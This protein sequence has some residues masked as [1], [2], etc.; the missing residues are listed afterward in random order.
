MKRDMD[1][2]RE[3]LLQVEARPTAQSIDLVE[4]PGH[5]QEEISY[6]VKLLADAGYLEAHDLR[7]LGPDGFKYAPSALTNDGH[8]F[9]DAARNNTVWE[10][11]KAKL[12]EIGGSAP[13][14][15][16]QGILTTML[17]EILVR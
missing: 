16:T 13:L 1:L 2:I 12:V 3:I 7:S 4:V 5:E 8:D 17:K 15:V 11:T 10:K 6:H 9:L 14:D